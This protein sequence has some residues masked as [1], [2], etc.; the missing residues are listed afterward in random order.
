M[1]VWSLIRK[2][3]T[4]VHPCAFIEKKLTR[5][6]LHL[7]CRH[8]I[9]ERLLESVFQTCF[10][11]STS[12]RIDTFDILNQY[13]NEIKNS[14]YL[15][16][17]IEREKL[18]S[19]P[20]RKILTENAIST[21]LI[22]AS[23]GHLRKDYAELNDL[24]LKFAGVNTEKTIKVP[25]ATSNARWMAKAIYALKTYL[26]RSQLELTQDSIDALERF[27]LFVVLIYV[28]FWNQ[29]PNVFDAPINDLTLLKKLIAITKSMKT[30]RRQRYKQC[31]DICG[32]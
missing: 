11:S 29:C 1:L 16:H 27:C 17:P 32:T 10:G 7:M 25:G 2:H 9:Y 13:W 31:Q 19:S 24:A 23:H 5:P 4:P 3:L 14:G 28:K 21:L 18:N 30:F 8:H 12:P 15:Y 20:L 22:H 26:F 6:L